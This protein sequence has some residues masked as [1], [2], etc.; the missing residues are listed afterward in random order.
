MRLDRYEPLSIAFMLQI[1]LATIRLVLN[2]LRDEG[3]IAIDGAG[4]GA[5]WRRVSPATTAGSD[6]HDAGGSSH[7]G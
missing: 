6:E 1:S 5:R 2:E 3:R 4:P 7:A